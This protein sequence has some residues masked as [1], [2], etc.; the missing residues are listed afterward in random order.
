MAGFDT[1]AERITG[2]L[3]V[4]SEAF[5]ERLRRHVRGNRREQPAV[6]AWQRLLP[7][8]RVVELVATEK[9]EAWEQFRDRHGDWGRDAAMWLARRHCGM[10][11]AELA[12]AVGGLA[13]PAVGHAVRRLECRRQNDRELNRVLIRLEAQL[14]ENAT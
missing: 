9:G 7:F 8:A 4:G 6:R 14:V 2:S 13:Y 10:T 1:L 5:L 12:A 3:A 11:Q